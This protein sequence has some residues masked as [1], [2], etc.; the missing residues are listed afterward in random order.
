MPVALTT[1][2][3]SLTCKKL[4][5][6]VVGDHLFYKE[7]EFEF[8]EFKNL[9]NY[10][11]VLPDDRRNAIRSVSALWDPTHFAAP[12]FTALTTCKGLE[13]LRVDISSLGSWFSLGPFDMT[14]ARGF[15]ELIK[16]RGLKSFQF[17]GGYSAPNIDF[18]IYVI[19]RVRG[20][21]PGP[22]TTFME[23][24]RKE[25]EEVKQYIASLVTEHGKY[26]FTEE[27]IQAALN[28]AEVNDSSKYVLYDESGTTIR[29]TARR[30]P[31]GIN[32]QG[33]DAHQINM[34]AKATSSTL[35]PTLSYRHPEHEL[36]ANDA[37]YFERSW[38]R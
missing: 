18:A 32:K 10:L 21:H 7:N 1:V 6:L 12:G 8:F 27:E 4:Y 37:A 16:I 9:I 23:D 29:N 2:D 35:K 19:C 26:L 13:N 38:E 11:A 25:V 24:F 20:Q 22:N 34:R 28:F 14:N 17:D 36:W 15:E 30:T 5:N 33:S 31:F 3:L